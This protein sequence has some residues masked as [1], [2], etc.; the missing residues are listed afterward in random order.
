MKPKTIVLFLI[1]ACC[2]LVASVGVSQYMQQASEN[3]GIEVETQSIFVAATDI[4]IGEKL[5]AQNVRLEEWPRDRIPEGAISE[6]SEFE[7]QY[8]R[9]RMYEGEPLLTAKLMDGSD[10]SD[11]VLTIPEGYRVVSVKVSVDSSVSGLV[12]PGDRVDLLVFLRKD[13]EIP[14][15]G[16]RTILRDVNIF[17]VDGETER[18]EDADGKSFDVRTVSLLVKPEQAE[19]VNL[20]SELG[21]LSLSLRRPDDMSGPSGEGVTVQS[22]LGSD[23]QETE[24]RNSDGDE[25]VD[26]EAPGFIGWLGSQQQEGSQ[27]PP[28]T[29]SAKADD[30]EPAWKM[31][32]WTGSGFREF[33]WRDEDELPEEVR[34][35]VHTDALQP[36]GQPDV[37]APPAAGLPNTPPPAMD[38]ALDGIQAELEGTL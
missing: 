11:A 8:P 16:T 9:Q 26:E 7:D 23:S 4:N 14:E 17:S 24:D 12:Q 21:R 19:M 34:R 3:T 20:A 13:N 1:A 28:N 29:E 33:H 10:R 22:L 27:Q 6:L 36:A 15:T 37:A 38:G 5:D 30:E 31:Q 25:Q 2:G 32:I 18:R 35:E